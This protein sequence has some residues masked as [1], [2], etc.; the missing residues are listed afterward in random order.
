MNMNEKTRQEIY[1]WR[2]IEARS[3]VDCSS[4][5]EVLYILSVFL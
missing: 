3:Y 4:G 5:N 1:V 2:S